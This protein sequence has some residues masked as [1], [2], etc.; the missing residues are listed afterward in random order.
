MGKIYIK[1][2]QHRRNYILKIFKINTQLGIE[3]RK[4]RG[5]GVVFLRL[6]FEFLYIPSLN[7]CVQFLRKVHALCDLL[8]SQ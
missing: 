1:I 2:N 4:T 8:I 3:N 5:I 6:I 7:F